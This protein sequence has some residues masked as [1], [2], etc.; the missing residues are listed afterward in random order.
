MRAVNAF[1]TSHGRKAV[2]G[3]TTRAAQHCA[4]NSGDTQACP[5]SYFWE[6]VTGH[7]GADVVHKIAEKSDGSQFLLDPRLK[8][9]Q[10]GWAYHPGAGG[11][12]CAI[13]NVY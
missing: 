9:I 7:N 5:Q 3:T 2:P 1:R 4:V 6:P 13:V 11:Y 10:V 12:E 8:S